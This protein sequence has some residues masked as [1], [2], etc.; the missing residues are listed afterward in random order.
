MSFDDEMLLMLDAVQQMNAMLQSTLSNNSQP[1]FVG[2][3][4]RSFQTRASTS[5]QNTDNDLQVGLCTVLSTAIKTITI[6]LISQRHHLP[7]AACRR[8]SVFGACL[9]CFLLQNLPQLAHSATQP[10]IPAVPAR[11]VINL[12][13]SYE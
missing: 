2:V 11:C 13:Q 3:T 5:Y 10:S 7:T 8:A 12:Q 4:S 6:L 1:A 9:C